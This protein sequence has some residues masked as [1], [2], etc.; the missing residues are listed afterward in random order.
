MV[1]AIIVSFLK[2]H[3]KVIEGVINFALKTGDFKK[4]TKIW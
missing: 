4:A 3:V 1:S 2:W